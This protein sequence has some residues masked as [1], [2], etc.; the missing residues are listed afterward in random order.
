MTT[1]DKGVRLET[2]NSAH[3]N[4]LTITLKKIVNQ[5]RKGWTLS[6]VYS[7]TVT[8]HQQLSPII[9]KAGKTHINLLHKLMTKI[10]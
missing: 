4:D 7:F 8:R 3:T 6:S 2:H 1:T 10:R 5:S 9:Q